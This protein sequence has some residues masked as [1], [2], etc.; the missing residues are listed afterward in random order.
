LP[1]P[2][3]QRLVEDIAGVLNQ[4]IEEVAL[5]FMKVLESGRRTWS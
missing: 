4:D 1:Q 3:V 2:I 5:S